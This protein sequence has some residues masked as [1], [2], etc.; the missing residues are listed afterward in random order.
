MKVRIEEICTACGF[1]TETCP[2][3]FA[4]GWETVQVT[5][6]EIPPK[7]EET[8]QQAVDECPLEAIIVE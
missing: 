1:C 6:D 7:F 5:V 8:V 4:M 2:D 3:V